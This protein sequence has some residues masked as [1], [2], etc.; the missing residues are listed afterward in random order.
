MR[1]WLLSLMG[2]ITLCYWAY[3]F[4]MIET[5]H[6]Y[7]MMPF[8]PTLFILATFGLKYVYQVKNIGP[9]IVCILLALTPYITYDL[10]RNDW[11]VERTFFLKDAFKYGE[12]LK[13]AAPNDAICILVNDPSQYI[14]GYLVDKKGFVF[15][16][17]NL[18]SGWIEDMI[19]NYK[20]TYMY[21]DTR[22]IDEDPS[23]RQYFEEMVM[24]R[25]N[26]RVFKL[27]VKK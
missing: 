1:F 3:E 2:F 4:N 15:R 20:A 22:K 8:L 17:D 7:Y 9:W 10:S 24:E 23:I 21:S 14:F 25:G 11:D 12:E 6:D 27:A 5:V 16:D 13:H 26:I 19:L 18:P